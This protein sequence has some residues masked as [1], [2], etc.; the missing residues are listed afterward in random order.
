MRTILNKR[1]MESEQII[2]LRR[3]QTDKGCD[4]ITAHESNRYKEEGIMAMVKEYTHPL[5]HF[6]SWL[7]LMRESRPE[8]VTAAPGSDRPPDRQKWPGKHVIINWEGGSVERKWSI[9][10]NDPGAYAPL[11]KEEDMDVWHTGRK[12]KTYV[13]SWLR[14]NYR[15]SMR[16]LSLSIGAHLL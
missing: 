5:A 2:N 12:K 3:F 1:F 16:G 4:V 10:L 7:A 9:L 8:E 15:A 14:G 6:D 13:R 11:D